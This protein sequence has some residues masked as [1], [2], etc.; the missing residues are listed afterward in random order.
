MALRFAASGFGREMIV[1]RTQTSSN[2]L[3]FYKMH[4][5]PQELAAR[6]Q[7]HRQLGVWVEAETGGKTNPFGTVYSIDENEHVF[8]PSR[9]VASTCLFLQRPI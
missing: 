4:R 6:E 9:K 8:E 5:T 3:E 7:L 1:P 2:L